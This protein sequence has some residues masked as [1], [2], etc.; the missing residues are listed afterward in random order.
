VSRL[1]ESAKEKQTKSEIDPMALLSYLGPLCLVPILTK[2]K[3][4]FAKF[5]AKQG[6]AL[7]IA[8]VAVWLLFGVLL[9]PLVWGVGTWSF[10]GLLQNLAYLVLVALSIIGI[11]NVVNKRETELPLIGEYAKKITFV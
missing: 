5:H 6:A 10:F 4:D 1:E 3:S 8:E 9:S 2:E 11:L 7:L